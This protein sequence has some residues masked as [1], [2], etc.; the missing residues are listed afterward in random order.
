LLGFGGQSTLFGVLVFFTKV[1]HNLL[2]GRVL[3]AT[4][5]GYY[6][7]AFAFSSMPLDQGVQTLAGILFPAYARLQ[8]DQQR[9]QHGY[10][11]SIR[12]LSLITF[13]TLI[14]LCAISAEF[15]HVLL[16]ATWAPM[17]KS[18]QVLAIMSMFMFFP[19]A[20]SPLYFAMGAPRYNVGVSAIEATGTVLFTLIA[21]PYGIVWVAVA[22]AAARA[23]GAAYSLKA[24][25]E[26]LP[27][28]LGGLFRV[29]RPPA[30]GCAVMM[31][32]IWAARPSVQMLFSNTHGW[33]ALLSFIVLGAGLYMGTVVL[34][35]RG[36]V[37]LVL[38][39]W[40]SSRSTAG[41]S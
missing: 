32:G 10:L 15:V 16:G 20:T 37:G 18:L 7:R 38:D 27:G 2:L 1:W 21:V 40:K 33:E 5:V 6:S 39:L 24:L 4:A 31:A 28:V 30:I 3:G 12:I 23:L 34:L 9:L 36:V 41:R 35:D 29:I 8:N 22:S 11:R 17:I 13:P 25:N 19:M 14:G 26:L